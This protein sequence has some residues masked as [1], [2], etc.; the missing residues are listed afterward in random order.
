MAPWY[1][2]VREVIG[3]IQLGAS[4]PL[5]KSVSA[6]FSVFARFIAVMARRPRLFHVEELLLRLS[7][8]CNQ[9]RPTALLAEFELYLPDLKTALGRSARVKVARRRVPRGRSF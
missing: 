4:I 9:P 7:D 1:K 8:I 5:A 3:G 2:Y 6:R